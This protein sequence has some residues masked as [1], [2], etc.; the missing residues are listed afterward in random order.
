MKRKIILIGL[1]SSLL[2][3]TACGGRKP[4]P[5]MVKRL[6]DEKKNCKLLTYEIENLEF[7]IHQ[8]LPKT[9][10][11]KQNVAYGVAGWFFLYVPWLLMDF[12]NAEATEYE[13]LAERHTHL[14]SIAKSKGCKILPKDYPSL[15]RV[16]EEYDVY[17]RLQPDYRVTEKSLDPE[18]LERLEKSPLDKVTDNKSAV[19]SGA[20]E[21]VSNINGATTEPIDV[22]PK[23]VIN[24][25]QI[26]TN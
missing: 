22:T 19:I 16:K 24:E 3:V 2:L 9:D 8:L 26:K 4:E 5:I 21:N 15:D 25:Q 1:I 13:A 18:V 11:L 10:K 14:A 23:Q 20:K 6:N 7:E 17:K 12:K